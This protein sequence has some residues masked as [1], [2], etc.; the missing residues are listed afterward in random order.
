MIRVAVMYPNQEGKWFDLEYYKS[1]HLKLINE[2]LKPEKIE[3]DYG[4]TGEE[5]NNSSYVAIGYLTFKNLE[6]LREGFMSH[7]S[8]LASD[9]ANY[10]NIQ[11]IYQVS[12]LSKA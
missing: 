9:V 6:H 12:D 4:V 7:E 2:K 3:I 10:T 5:D 11:P 1:K 8:D